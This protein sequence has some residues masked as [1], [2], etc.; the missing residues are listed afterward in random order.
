MHFRFPRLALAALVAFLCLAVPSASFADWKVLKSSDGK[1][2]EVVVDFDLSEFRVDAAGTATFKAST[3]IDG[4]EI[5]FLVSLT[6]PK[7]VEMMDRAAGRTVP[8]MAVTTNITSAGPATKNL[9]RRL[10]AQLAIPAEDRKQ[11]HVTGVR[12]AFS[13]PTTSSISGVTVL[14]GGMAALTYDENDQPA[15]GYAFGLALVIDAPLGR[16]TAHFSEAPGYGGIPR[17]DRTRVEWLQQRQSAGA[18]E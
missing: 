17:N 6:K 1:I 13:S 3:R 15:S 14:R 7:E 11:T 16:L 18:R 2:V 8:M 10:F 9:E 5:G 4:E 12:H